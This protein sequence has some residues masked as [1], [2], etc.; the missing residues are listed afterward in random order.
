[1]LVYHQFVSLVYYNQFYNLVNNNCFCYKFVHHGRIAGFSILAGNRWTKARGGK[2]KLPTLILFGSYYYL[3][4]F[5]D[6]LIIIKFSTIFTF[7]IHSFYDIHSIFYYNNTPII[8]QI[9]NINSNS[10]CVFTFSKCCAVGKYQWQSKRSA[11]VHT[12]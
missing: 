4:L 5:N 7:C 6:K 9:K 3:K 11:S 12:V 8:T 2:G 10:S 1:M